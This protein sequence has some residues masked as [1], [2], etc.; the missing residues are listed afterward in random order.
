[1]TSLSNA[2]TRYE[3]RKAENA[4]TEPHFR[5]C[6]NQGFLVGASVCIEAAIEGFSLDFLA[7]PPSHDLKIRVWDKRAELFDKRRMHGTDR[8]HL[9]HCNQHESV[10][11]LVFDSYDGLEFARA[12]REVAKMYREG[13]DEAAYLQ[14]HFPRALRLQDANVD[15]SSQLSNPS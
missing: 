12:A 10:L 14:A 9:G 11:T 5:T 6:G 1:M 3:T 15:A 2:K 7:Q 13:Q 8:A 4:K